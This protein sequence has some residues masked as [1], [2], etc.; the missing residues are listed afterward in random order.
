MKELELYCTA[1]IRPKFWV[2]R[3]SVYSLQS[4]MEKLFFSFGH[5]QN[6]GKKIFSFFIASK[7]SIAFTT[8]LNTK[9]KHVYRTKKIPTIGHISTPRSQLWVAYWTKSPPFGVQ[10]FK[11][12]HWKF[13]FFF[14][15]LAHAKLWHPGAC[16]KIQTFMQT[17]IFLCGYF[18]DSACHSS[19][20]TK[21]LNSTVIPAFRSKGR[22]PSKSP[23][24]DH[25]DN[26]VLSIL[27]KHVCWTSHGS[28]GSLRTN[29]RRERR[30]IL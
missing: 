14:T 22:W 7:L 3:V 4:I 5:K 10:V 19:K 29:L 9:F 26:F 16:K 27:E 21:H 28:L 12:G 20:L 13:T 25:P 24:L 6:F 17:S 23:N 30:L 11:Y 8:S 1:S 2:W 18:I 15:V